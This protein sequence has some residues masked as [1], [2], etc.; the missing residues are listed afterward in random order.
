MA[1]MHLQRETRKETGK[2]TL[3]TRRAT[4]EEQE[5]KKKKKKMVTMEKDKE[6]HRGIR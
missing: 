6:G 3:E 1:Q 4:Q 2:R 5:P